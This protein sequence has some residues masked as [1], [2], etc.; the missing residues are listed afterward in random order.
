MR[1]ETSER[2]DMYKYVRIFLSY[3][4]ETDIVGE[5]IQLQ[6]YRLKLYLKTSGFNLEISNFSIIMYLEMFLEIFQ[7]CGLDITF[8]MLKKYETL[9]STIKMQKTLIIS[10]C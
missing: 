1:M 3:L 9:E 6:N 5:I 7:V 8:K 10:N 2:T 4:N